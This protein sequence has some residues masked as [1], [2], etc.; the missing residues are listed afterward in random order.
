MSTLVVHKYGGTSVA[1]PDR[2]KA[3]A[4]RIAAEKRAGADVVVVVSAMGHTTDELTR[5]ASEVTREARREHPRELDMLLTAG[6]RITMALA[7]MAIRDCGIE[8]ISLTGSQAAIITDN[9]HTGARIEEVRTDRVRDELG[10]GRV[11]IVA[12]FQGVSR[13]REVTTLG[14]GGSD[15]TAVALGAALG[16]DRCDIFTDVAGVYTADPR[17]V[18]DARV[19]RVVDYDDMIEL[20][21]SGAQVM[22]PRAVEIGARYNVPIRVLSSFDDGDGTLISRRKDRME[23]L[24]LTGLASAGSQAKLIIRGLPPTMEAMCAVM[25]ELA[26]NG[27]SVDTLTPA[28]RADGR[29]QLQVTIHESDI[30]QSLALCRPLV[31]R[32]GG[33]AVDVQSGLTKVT[34]VGSG[35]TGLPGVYARSLEVLLAAGVD[36]HAVGT[37]SV[38]ISFLVESDAEDRTLQALHAAFDLAKETE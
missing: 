20:A 6:E 14:R 37:S 8:A 11:V 12:G 10:R 2:I 34:L 31:E 32:L 7:A 24:V 9:T 19:L 30:D 21:A 15:T 36:V 22:H 26:N 29:R 18:R 27:I 38:S 33:E 5:L 3:V 35:M 23:G 16:A 25:S 4:Q 1:S 17:R 28:D 13:A